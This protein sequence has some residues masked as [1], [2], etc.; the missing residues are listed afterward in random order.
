MRLR[1]M[2]AGLTILAAACGGLTGCSSDPSGTN[3]PVG[4]PLTQEESKEADSR[5]HALGVDY[6]GDHA[7]QLI[8]ALG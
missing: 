3:V 1:A 8:L 5:R 2:F 4:K 7:L 6:P